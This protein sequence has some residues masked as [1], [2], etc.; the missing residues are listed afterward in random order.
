MPGGKAPLLRPARLLE[1]QEPGTRQ[2]RRAGEEKASSAPRG[3]RRRTTRR[4]GRASERQRRGGGWQPHDGAEAQGRLRPELVGV[5][6]HDPPRPQKESATNPSCHTPRSAQ[7][8]APPGTIVPGRP[9]VL[10]RSHSLRSL[11]P[12]LLDAAPLTPPSHLSASLR[13]LRCTEHVPH[14]PPPL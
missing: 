13:P 5:F 2:R 7:A 3:K 8:A 9:G 10:G 11:S 12:A 14:S 4:N 1:T 6:F